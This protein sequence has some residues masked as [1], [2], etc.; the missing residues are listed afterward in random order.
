MKG[1]WKFFWSPTARWSLGSIFIVGGF[2]GIIFWGGFNTFMEYTNTL[3]FCV[4]C[5]EMEMKVYQEYKQSVH[6]SNPSGV[7]AICSDC[8]VPKEWGPKL[9]RKI[10]ASNEV[11]HKV[12]GTIDTPEKF[13]ENRYRLAKNV[14]AEMEGNDSHE[15]RNCHDYGAMHWDKQR[16]RSK[17]TMQKA[18]EDGKTC[19]ECHKGIAHKLPAEYLKELEDLEDD[20]KPKEKA[21][22]APKSSMSVDK[23]LKEEE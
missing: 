11:L 18:S 17:E 4:S 10:K 19:I 1:L 21:A 8:H 23:F 20:V 14:W 15:C 2:A 12:L 9:I 6:Y 5:H 22:P 3:Q 7:R 13:E 16:R